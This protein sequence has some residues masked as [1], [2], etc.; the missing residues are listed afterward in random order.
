MALPFLNG[1]ANKR[2]QLLSVDLGGRTTKAVHLQRKGERFVL[3]S[4]ALLDAPI[5]EKNLSADL[6]GEHLKAVCQALNAKTRNI[7]LAIGVSDSIVRHAELPHMPVGDMR[8]ILKNN[9]KNY[10]QQDLPGHVF[11][12]FIIPP[13]SDAPG[14]K[15]AAAEKTK[16][17]GNP[18]SKVL[19]A[20]A[21]K[22]LVEEMQNAVKSTGLLPDQIVP[23]LLGPVNAFELAMPEIFTREVIA[24]VDIGFRNTSI[25]ILQQGDLVL[26]RVVAIG[27]DRLTTGLAESLGISYAEA[28]GIKVGMP[29][30]VQSNLEALVLPLGREL[31]ASIDFF[32]HQQDQTVSQVFISGGSA[33]SEFIVQTLQTELVA[34]CKAWN[35][36]GFLELAL[37]PQQAAEIE[38]IAPQL[39]VAVGAAAGA[40]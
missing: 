31:R 19:V 26:S 17:G 25:C 9:T 18:K 38:H 15:A 23:G 4:Y 33:R 12:C 37:P 13:R 2:D 14:G 36:L 8:Q 27:G 32:E 28:E 20:G 3:S 24:L 30:E 22:Q 40:F 29:T 1:A 7:S 6:L 5:Y 11:D 21:R 34:E 16:L 39:A 35:P 10:L